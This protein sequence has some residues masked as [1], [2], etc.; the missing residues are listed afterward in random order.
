[1]GFTEEVSFLVAFTAGMLSFFSPCVLP[2]IP[3][4][5]SFITGFSFE[6]LTG[7]VNRAHIR[8]E[9]IINSLLFILGFSIVFILMGASSSFLGNALLRHQDIIRKVGG[10]LIVFFGLYITG[11]IKLDFLLRE[12]KVHHLH[13]KPMG[14]LGTVL[15]GMAFAAGWTPCV[16]PILG[17]I[18]LYAST[19]GSVS[20]GMQLLFVY[21]LGLG[22][23]FFLTSLAINSFL[24]HVKKI[25]RYM[26][27]ITVTGGVF[28]IFVGVLIFTNSYQIFAGYVSMFLDKFQ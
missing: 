9:T 1:M 11:I 16:G 10:A 14:L 25:N 6:E 12:R 27:A 19:E 26:K 28:L 4:Y 8:K 15:V 23:P 21:S 3:S 2:L 22:I 13:A 24:L 5:V 20:R 18:L 17:S 7:K